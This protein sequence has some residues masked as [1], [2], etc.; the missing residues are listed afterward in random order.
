MVP[1]S[2]LPPFETLK[3]EHHGPSVLVMA[4][5]RPT[6]MNAMVPESYREWRQVMEH[7]HATPKVRVLV[8]TGKGPAYSAG[9][10]LVDAKSEDSEVIRRR[11]DVTREL[12]RLLVTSPIPIIAAVNGP[13]IGYGCTT[14]GLFDLVLASESALF[15]TPFAELAFSAE[16]CSS[17]TFPRIL[18]PATAN[19]M[20]LFGR[21]MS[22]R[23][24]HQRGF[25]ARLAKPEELMPLA[26]KLARQ[27]ASR[28]QEAIRTSRS[29]LRTKEYVDELVRVNDLEMD[30]FYRCL[31]SDDA[32]Q[33]ISHMMARLRAKRSNTKPKM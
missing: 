20:L 27:L 22:A 2:Q 32:R 28:P 19:D 33:A 9:Q 14:L 5:N 18:G 7:V 29:L 31:I 23:E 17:V 30:H 15:R 3:V 10:A 25:V 4:F 13:A 12:T 26:I 11:C 21:T 8:I 6:Q 24:M 1:S 16:G